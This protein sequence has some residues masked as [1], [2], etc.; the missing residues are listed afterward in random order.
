MTYAAQVRRLLLGSAIAAGAV[1]AIVLGL[2]LIGATDADG[3]RV[4]GR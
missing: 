1:T 3:A 4:P 2:V